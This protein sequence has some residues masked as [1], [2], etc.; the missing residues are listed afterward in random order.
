MDQIRLRLEK[1]K[2]K[3]KGFTLVELIVVIAIIGI[4]AAVLLPKYFGF[5]DQARQSGAISDA[6]NIRSLAE[7]YYASYGVW[8]DFSNLGSAPSLGVNV[9]GT[10]SA[11]TT[12][13]V[14]NAGLTTT[15]NISSPSFPG[16]I[17]VGGA[18]TSPLLTTDGSFTYISYT[19]YSCACDPN[20][21]ITVS[22]S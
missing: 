19:G 11:S 2:Q 8:P 15:S 20:G 21:I 10:S 6:K 4:L 16:F 17:K 13:L 3:K 12:S 18:A 14:V 9:A 1:V 7:T 22:N 5:T